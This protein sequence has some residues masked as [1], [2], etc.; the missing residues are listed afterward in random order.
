MAE[1]WYLLDSGAGV[2]EDNMAV[3]ELLLE[4]VGRLKKPFLRLY[5]L[6]VPAVTFGYF[7]RVSDV[8]QITSTRP[9]IR[10]PT[11]GGI[12]YHGRDWTYSVVVPPSHGW[13]G[14]AAI[15]SYA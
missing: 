2:P 5:G 13:Y 1:S 14:L 7:Q 8:K 12:V 4:N 11:G 6:N 9:L 15:E 3:D 10:R